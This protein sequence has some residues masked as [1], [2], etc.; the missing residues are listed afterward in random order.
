[1]A[2]KLVAEQ[3]IR[4]GEPS[5]VEGASP[6][7]PFVVV[8][9]DDGDTGYLYALDISRADNPI[10]DALQIYNVAAVT[11][12]HLPSTVQLV[13]SQDDKK[14]ALLINRYPHAIFDFETH[15]GYCRTGFPPPSKNGWTKH[16]H[17]WDDRAEELFR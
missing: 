3:E 4:V 6:T 11:D 8:F 1:M 7:P 15:R 14:A 12:R 13:W 17:E 2:A 9:E 5:V 10:V 16:S